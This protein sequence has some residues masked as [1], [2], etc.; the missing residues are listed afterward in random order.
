MRHSIGEC[1]DGRY[2]IRSL[3]GE[4]GMAEVYRALDATTGRDVVLKLPHMAIAGDLA[5]F[6]RYRREMEI[7]RG[8]DHP[9]LQRLL[10]DEPNARCMVLEYVEGEPLRK[11]F[12]RSGPLAV[13]DVVRIGS[14]LARTLQYV[15]DRGVIHRDLKPDNILI[16]PDG[17]VTLKLGLRDRA[18]ARLAAADLLASV[19]RR[20]HARLHGARAGAWRAWGCP[21]RHLRAGNDALRTAHRRRAVP[22]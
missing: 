15:H 19:E 22:G 3:L 4:G 9:G 12:G 10:S 17:R 6:N 5:A 16:G 20:W 14:D 11:Y 18:A 21:D 2:E 8:L 7:A 13:D 1:M